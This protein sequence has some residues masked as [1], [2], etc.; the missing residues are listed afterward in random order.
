[1][2]TADANLI[3]KL[4]RYAAP[5]FVPIAQSWTKFS[6][7]LLYRITY[8]IYYDVYKLR[9]CRQKMIDHL[10]DNCYSL[11]IQVH[12]LLWIASFSPPQDYK[13]R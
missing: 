11:C 9:L 4:I 8:I 10:T 1:M 5:I 12:C 13:M 7:S 3:E 2:P 6:F